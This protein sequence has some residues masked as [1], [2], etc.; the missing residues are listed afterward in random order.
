M[1]VV[2]INQQEVGTLLPMR[3]C[4]GVMERVFRS[5]A[6][7]DCSLP[8]RQ[9]MWLPEKIGAL[10][11]MP[12]SWGGAGMLGVKVVTFFPGNEGTELDSHQGAVLLFEAQRG[13]L[14][15]MID[16]TSITAIRT[17]AVSAVATK[18]LATEG[19][20]D[21]AV[22]GSGVQAQMHLEA[23]RIARPITRVRVASKTL[24]HAESFATDQSARHSLTIEPCPTVR[25]AVEGADLI[26]TTTS[27]REPVLQ[28]DWI[29]PGA[30]INAVGSS[31]SSA[32]ELDAAAVAKARLVVDRTE[33]AL[34]EAGDFLLAKAEGA[35]GDDHIAAE[36][37]DVLLGRVAGRRS[38]DEITLFKSV[39]LAV[40][41]LAAALHVY[42]NAKGVG[43]GERTEFG[44]S[45]R[46]TH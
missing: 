3:E 13:R 22:I 2:I 36:L 25:E 27:A 20:A 16:A 30:H 23:M 35:I 24:K 9:I 37:G 42:E 29:K 14:L 12:S 6:E 18:L 33:S 28:G 40:E 1:E 41:D 38:D 31:V 11:L 45:R 21:L 32:R 46:A 39:G 5:L 43:A 17:A 8:L 7:G 44:G 34:N 19:A 15:A 10:G 4:I 26:C